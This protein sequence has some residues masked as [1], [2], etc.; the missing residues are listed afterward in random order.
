MAST[1]STAVARL[2][3]KWLVEGRLASQ[4]E[5]YLKTW[6]LTGDTSYTQMLDREG[7]DA[8]E[9]SLRDWNKRL[10]VSDFAAGMA[11][12]AGGMLAL[13]GLDP[14]DGEHASIVD[15]TKDILFPRCRDLDGPSKMVLV[16][17]PQV[18]DCCRR[19]LLLVD[20]DDF[21]PDGRLGIGAMTLEVGISRRDGTTAA[22]LGLVVPQRA[23]A[24]RKLNDAL[25]TVVTIEQPGFINGYTYNSVQ[26]LRHVL[27][28]PELN[29]AAYAPSPASEYLDDAVGFPSAINC[30]ADALPKLGK[31]LTALAKVIGSH[32]HYR[33]T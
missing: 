29:Q 18:P 28:L 33:T 32:E 4:H 14:Q 19:K 5:T 16:A 3:R 26:Y 15:T 7:K 17:N 23:I 27:C 11:P 22:Q 1:T 21:A 2:I 31:Y 10:R 24:G 8:A 6:V 30:F 12:V 20:V 9:K 13:A 25:C